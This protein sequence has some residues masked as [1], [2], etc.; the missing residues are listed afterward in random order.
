MLNFEKYSGTVSF[1]PDVCFANDATVVGILLAKERAKISAA[2]GDRRKT[3][4]GE[5]RLDL[6]GLQR[7]CEPANQ[8]R[9]R[10]LRRVR[11][12]K[13]APPQVHFVI[14]I[15][16]LRDRRQVRQWFDPR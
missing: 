16:G 12:R 2:Q 3:L 1:R 10:G 4:G 13:Q 6:R 11:R 14:S 9:E 8:L 7:V 15:T 5:L